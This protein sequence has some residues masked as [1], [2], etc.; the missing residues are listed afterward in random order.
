MDKLCP[1][2]RVLVV[3]P[4]P[5]AR[6]DVSSAV[7]AKHVEKSH[8]LNPPL[9]HGLRAEPSTRPRTRHGCASNGDRLTPMPI[10]GSALQSPT[11]SAPIVEWERVRQTL[12]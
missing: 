7:T 5:C 12:F 11:G 9:S 1:A 2:P 6:A 3:A 4:P 10:G 8:S